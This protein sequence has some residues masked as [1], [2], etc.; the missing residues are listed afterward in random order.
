MAEISLKSPLYY[1]F[2]LRFCFY[3]AVY[4][5]K[6]AGG[7]SCRISHISIL[8]IVPFWWCYNMFLCPYISCKLVVRSK[9]SI[10][11]RFE[12]LSQDNFAGGGMDFIRRHIMKSYLSF[13][14][15]FSQWWSFPMSIIWGAKS[16]YSNSSITCSFISSNTSLTTNYLSLT[17]WLP[18]RIILLGKHKCLISFL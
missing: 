10:E 16:W 5:L 8:L 12:F 4:L 13:C 3:F 17:I 9:D 18:R 6:K 15:V 1:W 11:S 2:P 7:L 14:N